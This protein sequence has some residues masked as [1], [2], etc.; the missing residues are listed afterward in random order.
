MQR[1]GGVAPDRMRAR[2]AFDAQI[3]ALAQ[4]VFVLGM[5]RGAAAD[6]LEHGATPSSSS[7]SS[8][9]VEEPM[10]TLTPA[11]RRAAFRAR[12]VR[13]VFSRVAADIEGE[14]AMHAVVAARDLVGE[15]L[16]VVVSGSVLGISNT[17]VTPPSTARARAGLQ[18][19]L[20]GQA[21]LAEMHM[22][23]DHAGQD[24]QAGGS[25]SSRRPTRAT[26]RR[27]PQCAR[28]G[29]RCRARPRRPG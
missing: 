24:M 20:V 10:N 26:D 27:L 2:I 7:T 15:R 28:R 4:A 11:A 3:H 14:I 29:C 6:R 25:R 18:V 19:F 5:E 9:P 23:V 1:G 16:G 12:R 17:A 13:A 8:E 22:A 21:R